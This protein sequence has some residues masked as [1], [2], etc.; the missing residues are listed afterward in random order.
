MFRLTSF[1]QGVIGNR[2]KKVPEWDSVWQGRFPD[3]K[4]Q[5]S[6]K[7]PPMSM[8]QRG[9]CRST[10]LMLL[11]K[12]F[13]LSIP[14]Y[15]LRTPRM[16]QTQRCHS[17]MLAFCIAFWPMTLPRE[18]KPVTCQYHLVNRIRL[19]VSSNIVDRRRTNII[20]LTKGIS[21]SPDHQNYIIGEIKVKLSA[22]IILEI[23]LIFLALNVELNC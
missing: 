19:T 23:G 18:I 21:K 11:A 2:V 15:S 7:L 10:V 20:S 13:V 5:K 3:N 9:R 17:K 22:L 6:Q 14:G 8:P 16:H 4:S 1:F 12:F